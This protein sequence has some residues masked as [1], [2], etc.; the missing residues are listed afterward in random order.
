MMGGGTRLTLARRL[1][2]TSLGER[3]A[4]D[5]RVNR[6]LEPPFVER[7]SVRPK[8]KVEF[9]LDNSIVIRYTIQLYGKGVNEKKWSN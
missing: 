8:L 1:T 3:G 4:K 5:A 7:I 6:V 9:L 2:L